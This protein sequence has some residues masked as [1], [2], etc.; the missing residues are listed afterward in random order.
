MSKKA[1]KKILK[2]TFKNNR[3]CQQQ[4][5]LYKSLYF[6]SK[7]FKVFKALALWADAFL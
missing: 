7:N 2:K 1:N 3:K 4:K 5:N 6:L